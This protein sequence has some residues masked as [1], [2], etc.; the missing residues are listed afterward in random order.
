[1]LPNEHK[2]WT[3]FKRLAERFA[4]STLYRFFHLGK[5]PDQDFLGDFTKV[6]IGRDNMDAMQRAAKKAQLD[7]AIIW[8]NWPETFCFT[9]YEALAAGAC[10]IANPAS[11]NVADLV[12]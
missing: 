8:S 7:V 12:K 1:G 3:V 6:E 9:A 2:G 11:G 4:G 5:L 10:V